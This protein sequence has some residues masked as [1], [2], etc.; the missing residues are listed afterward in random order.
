MLKKLKTFFKWLLIA[1]FTLIIGFVA[2]LFIYRDRII[3]QVLREVNNNLR[4]PLQAEQ[5]DLEFF[6]GFPNV[7]IRFSQVLLAGEGE[8][9]FLEA[10]NVYVLLNP[11]AMLQGKVDVAR[12]EIADAQLNIYVD[13]QNRNNLGA[14]IGNSQA[15][16]QDTTVVG[17][18]HINLQTILL[19]NVALGY[20]NAFAGTRHHWL[21]K[22]LQ[23]DFSL[24]NNVYTSSIRGQLTLKDFITRTW[25]AKRQRQLALTAN[26][27]YDNN[28]Q[29]LRIIESSLHEAGATF[30][31][32]GD[33][34][35][36]RQPV[37]NISATGE[38]VTLALLASYLPPRYGRK[39]QE[40]NSKG[41]I[42]Y[43]LVVEGKVTETSLPSVKGRL[44]LHN[45]D[46][47]EKEFNANIKQLSMA[48]D[49]VIEDLGNLATGSL[50]I[51][52]ARGLLA[53]YPFT[54]DLSITDFRH[55]RYQ[56]SFK[57]TVTTSWLLADVQFPD[58]ES[59]QG[60]IAIDLQTSGRITADG[61]IRDADSG[62]SFKFNEVAF[63]WSD[64]VAI[65]KI[66][67][68]MQF[69]GNTLS[70]SNMQIK[71]S[72]S[73]VV[74]NGSVAEVSKA[75]DQ[76]GN[77][78][79]VADVRSPGLDIND[80]V[81]LIKSAP[82]IPAGDTTA[83]DTTASGPD[84]ALN[85]QLAC[86]FDK[87]NFK[88]F[89]GAAVAGEVTF[90]NDVL[91]VVDLTGRSMGGA[92]RITGKLK[93]MPNRDIYISADANARGVYLDSLFY[94][95]NNFQQDFIT[96]E[97]L[98]GKLYAD[99]TA[100]MYFDSTWQIKRPLLTSRAKVKVVGGE[101]NNFAPI[102]ELSAYI[103][104]EEDNLSHL[105]FSDLTNFVTIKEDTVFIPEMSIQTNVRNIALAGYHTLDQHINYQLAVPI[106]SERVDKDEAFGT[107]Q[108]SSK[109]VPNLLF[110]I[111]GTTSDYRVNYDLKRATGNV[112]KLLDITR[113][114]K[115]KEVEPVDSS[116]LDEEEFDWE[117]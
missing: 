25:A 46:L 111:K 77:L 43:N 58:Y 2:A 80:I 16:P 116:F 8:L 103:N 54:F 74:I 44:Q 72:Q 59:G 114:F 14:I 39:L 28:T 95:F 113:I 56:G 69:R 110:K 26:L 86:R 65:D 105:R 76:S 45:V 18:A 23:G 100:S 42:D 89:R 82:V 61:R 41:S 106:I 97:H 109:G 7:A 32:S 92:T 96:D 19:R 78:L 104:D 64:S 21:V 9:P 115:Q 5:I 4:V 83:T 87:L 13:K 20:V 36:G 93:L 22:K 91:E 30:M 3:A 1:V 101:L 94:T 66:K 88:R 33:V 67:G 71:W 38:K 85:L 112:L 49:I 27:S 11:Y 102:M 73:E 10:G 55:P 90:A 68:I 24:Q 98:K 57:G 6:H 48:A 51:A 60:T 99:I 53:E 37:V 84:Y 47:T 62:G 70:L 117:N 29:R 52:A 79:L 107:V 12:I 34:A 40:Y 15:A 108:K 81:T 31:A 63:N 17:Q 75:L 50:K 35:F